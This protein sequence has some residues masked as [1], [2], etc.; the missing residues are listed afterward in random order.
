MI[1]PDLSLSAQYLVCKLVDEMPADFSQVFLDRISDYPARVQDRLCAPLDARTIEDVTALLHGTPLKDAATVAKVSKKFSIMDGFLSQL[2]ASNGFEQRR[3]FVLDTLQSDDI[4]A[5]KKMINDLVI[6][7]GDP[8][9]P[10]LHKLREVALRGDTGL[11]A[12]LLVLDTHRALKPYQND[13]EKAFSAMILDGT[14]ALL[15]A[16]VRLFGK[17]VPPHYADHL[18]PPLPASIT[19]LEASRIAEGLLRAL[20][21]RNID[22]NIRKQIVSCGQAIGHVAGNDVRQTVHGGTNILLPTGV[23]PADLEWWAAQRDAGLVREVRHGDVPV[24]DWN[25]YV[26]FNQSIRPSA[27][28]LSQLSRLSP[29]SGRFGIALE[30]TGNSY[31][32]LITGY[33]GH[34]AHPIEIGCL[35]QQKKQTDGPAGEGLVWGGI[36]LPVAPSSSHVTDEDAYAFIVRLTADVDIKPFINSE[37]CVVVDG[38]DG[39]VAHFQS[40]PNAAVRSKPVVFLSN[41]TPNW[42]NHI[43]QTVQTFWRYAGAFTV[44]GAFLDVHPMSGAI[45]IDHGTPD[46]LGFAAPSCLL[47]MPLRAALDLVAHDPKRSSMMM[48][49]LYVEPD[50]V[51]VRHQNRPEGFDDH[52]ISLQRKL[53]AQVIP[54]ADLDMVYLWGQSAKSDLADRLKSAAYWPISANLAALA[55]PQSALLRGSGVPDKRLA[56]EILDAIAKHGKNG[57]LPTEYDQFVVGVAEQPAILSGLSAEHLRTVLELAVQ[58]PSV[59]AI[60]A[61]LQDQVEAVALN[62]PEL[63]PA[64]FMVLA[65]GLNDAE[66][67]G[68]IR[69]IDI[70]RVDD[71]IEDACEDDPEPQIEQDNSDALYFWV[72]DVCRR[73]ASGETMLGQFLRLSQSNP[74]ILGRKKFLRYFG[75]LLEEFTFTELSERL[76][77]E[78]AHLMKQAMGLEDAFA[79]AL[80]ADDRESLRSLLGQRSALD[81]VNLTKWGDRL[82]AVSNELRVLELPVQD[83]NH[84][85]VANVHMRTLFAV[86]FSDVGALKDLAQ[87]GLLNETTNLG[88]V[89]HQIIGNSDPLNAYIAGFFDQSPIPALQVEGQNT[90]AVFANAAASTNQATRKGTRCTDAVVSVIISAFNPDMDLLE[91]SIQ[92]VL[93][94]SHDNVEIIVVDDESDKKSAKQIA[95]IVDGCEGDVRLIRMK[96][97]A[98]PYA[99]RNRAISDS[100]GTF[101]AIQD[102][103]DWAH[104]DRFA[105]QVSLLA[106][107]PFVQVV[108]TPHIRIDKSGC[109]QL[110]A[111]FEV[112]GDGPMTSMFRRSAFERAGLF[113]PVRSR[114]D[115]EMRERIRSYFGP[116]ALV[117]L[118]MPM[119]LCF[120]DS[121]TLSQQIKSEKLEHL[122][123]FRTNV[124]NRGDLR[125]LRRR[126]AMLE[127]KDMV[128]VPLVLRSN[129]P[130][131]PLAQMSPND[132]VSKPKE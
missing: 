106:A 63:L 1:G 45:Q 86:L 74:D 39:L 41:Q 5:I 55:G 98:G 82:R 53:A 93:N 15:P 56:E 64:M 35:I 37:A 43:V 104:P 12:L 89:G 60:A 94:Q 42:A 28:Q 131:A 4:A 32:Q 84:P 124:S 109:V 20:G 66:L 71:V 51:I 50:N 46:G 105:E 25:R 80:R 33:V 97:N 114:G 125:P 122:Q 102:A 99:G 75:R 22:D 65:A 36:D 13:A 100:K 126:N 40:E 54:A 29:N 34:A 10:Y 128:Q 87:N 118:P 24:A 16:M 30:G 49:G 113:A 81:K 132:L 129:Q 116:H 101:I 83:I 78:T 7:L 127:P 48:T 44:T 120:A 31:E 17:A 72:A 62:H 3:K 123:I 73:F 27:I 6:P 14:F 47:G 18:G 96:S 88:A 95:Q 91:M 67:Q 19:P 26:Q 11:S 21:L 61:A 57:L 58:C 79:L 59:D 76:G 90:A 111:N 85:K 121:Q 69:R 92:S 68:A 117:E 52:L 23:G 115:I 110:E 38:L 77:S 119:Q 8:E 103:D 108:T 112:L 70:V 130:V 9:L 107:D 2:I